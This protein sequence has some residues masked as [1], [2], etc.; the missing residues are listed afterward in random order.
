MVENSFR[1][2]VADCYSCLTVAKDLFKMLVRVLQSN[3]KSVMWTAHRAEDSSQIHLSRNT[4]QK[5]NIC[6]VSFLI[7][8]KINK[9][10]QTNVV[11]LK[12]YGSELKSIE[13]VELSSTAI[14]YR[15][16]N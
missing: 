11:H 4:L 15:F 8:F 5:G 10:W 12:K 6:L 1:V 7:K 3:S 14:K 2:L 16:Y 9:Q 13:S